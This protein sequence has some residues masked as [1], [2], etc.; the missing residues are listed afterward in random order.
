M[1][2]GKGFSAITNDYA[3]GVLV[4]IESNRKQDYGTVLAQ[5]MVKVRNA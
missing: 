4:N 1:F 2:Y 5:I 3:A